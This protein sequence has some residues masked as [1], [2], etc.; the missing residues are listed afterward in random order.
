MS[1]MS[2]YD[3]VED[4]EP[5]VKTQLSQKTL[6]IVTN[7]N[8]RKTNTRALPTKHNVELFPQPV[9]DM[10]REEAEEEIAL[11][12]EAAVYKVGS[13]M[14]GENNV[15]PG[16][17]GS[18]GGTSGTPGKKKRGS[19]LSSGETVKDAKSQNSPPSRNSS[20][21]STRSPSSAQ[22]PVSAASGTSS[23]GSSI[24]SPFGKVPGFSSPGT[25]SR[26]SSNSPEPGTSSGDKIDGMGRK[27]KEKGTSASQTTLGLR[28]KSTSGSTPKRS[29]A[30]VLSKARS[31]FRYY[32][33]MR[34]RKKSGLEEEVAAEA[35]A[36]SQAQG[37]AGSDASAEIGDN[38]DSTDGSTQ[39][40][41]ASDVAKSSGALAYDGDNYALTD[42][43]PSSPTAK[44]R[45]ERF[46]YHVKV[47]LLGDSGVGKT[48]LMM[49]FSDNEF[50][51][52]LMSTAG[53]DFKVRYLE[54]KEN[55]D[56]FGRQRIKCQIWDTAGQ[57][58]FH[59][60]TRTYYRGSHGIAL[61]YDATNEQSF[62][63]INYWMNNIKNHASKEVS[64]VLFGNKIDLPNRKISYEQGKAV[65][66][67]YGCQFYETSAKDGTNVL[68]AFEALSVEAVKSIAIKEAL[69]PTNISRE[70]I[71]AVLD[72]SAKKRCII[73]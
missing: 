33:G 67:Q 3:S 58:R 24:G 13:P 2:S 22:S 14:N 35:A 48:S 18:S 43:A 61:V 31:S 9:V 59:V 52:N 8:H 32:A 34:P 42:S 21:S 53:V 4:F 56:R 47:L 38:L 26:T 40:V 19:Y 70:N 37:H 68:Q 16:S 62:A 5:I 41:A 15:I 73:L 36:A 6:D 46:D 54:D 50:N 71:S 66:D 20:G 60:I 30:K 69:A 57:E 63:Q 10:S 72:N 45:D 49:R 27:G 55:P 64:V 28:R 23:G 12:E 51:Q 17:L 65:A 11:E 1:V 25:V 7:L 44:Q 39:S 29:A